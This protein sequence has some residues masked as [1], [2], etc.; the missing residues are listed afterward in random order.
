MKHK[1]ELLTALQNNRIDIALISEMHFTH[2]SHFSSPDFQTFK[3]NHPENTAHAGAA[4]I[5]RSTLLFLPLPPYQTDHIQSCGISL[6]LN[7]IP[8]NIY[9]VYCPPPHAISINQLNDIFDVIGNK[10]IIEGD[11]NAK[12]TQW[13]CRVNNPHGNT[14]KTLMN[15]LNFK[16]HAPSL[17]TYRPTLPRKRPDILDIF[18][19]KIPNSLHILTINLDDFCSDHSCVLLTIDNAPL[20]KSKKPSLD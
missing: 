6:I 3:T 17:L 13:G 14:L 9:A 7:N 4:V 19:T 15:S 18:I 11:I 1:N 20:F 10:F 12:N 16:I 2:S 5:I 8:I